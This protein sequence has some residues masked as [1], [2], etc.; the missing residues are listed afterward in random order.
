[1]DTSAE[2]IIV[3]HRSWGHL[4]KCLAGIGAW[5]VTVVDN[6]GPEDT[7]ETFQARYSNVRFVTAPNFGFGHACN[8][9]A[10]LSSA[11]V[12]LFL[13]PDTVPDDALIRGLVSA[14]AQS[15]NPCIAGPRLVDAHG[16]PQ[17]SWDV[18]PS[19]KTATGLM[20]RLQ[21]RR[22]AHGD[23]RRDVPWISGAALCISATLFQ[24]LN[25]FDDGY[26]MYSEDV[27]LCFRARAAGASVN[28]IA[29]LTLPHAHGG[30]S[31]I[32]A[33]TRVLTRTEALVSRLR[34]ATLHMRGAHRITYLLILLASRILPIL[35]LAGASFLVPVPSMRAR[36]AMVV[37][38]WASFLNALRGEKVRSTRSAPDHRY[39]N[40]Q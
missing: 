27:D 10:S 25:G 7:L 18:F 2:I 31:R 23:D 11:N 5:Q 35:I 40:A 36:R 24:E 8:L 33:S 32:D 12:L 26:F 15:K 9:G 37:P 13:N 29:H 4:E 17:K 39:C 1:M 34:F 19:W 38:V 14:V 21:R 20:R 3:N 22:V 16:R 30:S 28:Q 6:G